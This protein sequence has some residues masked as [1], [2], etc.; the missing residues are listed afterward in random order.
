VR[1]TRYNGGD[2]CHD[3]LAEAFASMR[4]EW[5]DLRADYDFMRVTKHRRQ[6]LRLGG[7]ADAHTRVFMDWWRSIEQPRDADRNDAVF[8]QMVDR[9]AN[10]IFGPGL[11]CEPSTP[12]AGLNR[13]LKEAWD[14]YWTDP[15]QVDVAGRHDGPTYERLG[16]RHLVI[17]GDFF[18]RRF[19]AGE[20]EGKLQFLEADRVTSLSKLN[21]NVVYGIELGEHGN[22][23]AYH[24]LR[25]PPDRVKWRRQIVPD[26]Q[27]QNAYDRV[28][29]LGEDGLPNVMHV[30]DPSRFSQT[31][32]VSAFHAVFDELAMVQDVNFAKLLQQKLVS[33]V[34]IFLE[35]EHDYQM[36]P[37]TRESDSDGN[38]RYYEKVA[39]AQVWRVR[40]GEK[41][42]GFSPR[43]PNPGY[44]EHLRLL[45]R[46]CGG[47]LGLPLSLV[48]LDTSD[49]TFHGYRGEMQQARIGFRRTQNHFPRQLHGPAYRWFV[50]RFMRQ[51]RGAVL[52]HDREMT[53]RERQVFRV[54]WTGPTWPYVEPKTDAE[55][56]EIR[57]QN[58]QASPRQIVGERGY[59]WEQIVQETVEDYA[60]LIRRAA[61]AAATLR[62]ETDEEV[63]W[64]DL[65]GLGLVAK[66]AAPP[67]SGVPREP[68]EG[69]DGGAVPERA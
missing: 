60:A 9:A 51:E 23:L 42:S 25:L 35:R 28:P 48:L 67:T 30:Y 61:E 3:S 58:W 15:R 64:R 56:D 14:D 8:G 6:R 33:S 29:A 31:R 17:E 27:D 5:R 36:G 43:V 13:E 50:R 41:I 20:Y 26:I 32:G 11:Q 7:T 22:P 24:V 10:N 52:P 12:D 68:G 21:D 34:A 47:A 63:T 66:G 65:L 4:D 57:R 54:R 53:R 19:T 55:A 16:Y 59:R 46:I 49:T 45:L 62:D 40:P 69:G 44:A 39:P 1:F 37:R 18:V 2:L 38:Y